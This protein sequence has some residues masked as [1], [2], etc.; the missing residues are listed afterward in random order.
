MFYPPGGK[1]SVILSFPDEFEAYESKMPEFASLF[2]TYHHIKLESELRTVSPAE[3]R[4]RATTNRPA[5][6]SS[7]PEDSCGGSEHKASTG[8][9][10]ESP[11]WESAESGGMSENKIKID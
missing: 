8:S 5:E 2:S 3:R 4:R 1:H 6:I 9:P 11:V 7:D 10:S